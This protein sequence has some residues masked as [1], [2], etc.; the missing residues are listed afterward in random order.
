MPDERRRAVRRHIGD[1]VP[2]GQFGHRAPATFEVTDEHVEVDAVAPVVAEDEPGAVGPE[3]PEAVDHVGIDDEIAFVET[4]RVHDV[5]LHA[6]V[7]AVVAAEHHD[8]RIDRRGNRAADPLIGVGDLG[9][10]ASACRHRP[11]LGDAGDV[12]DKD[13]RGSVGGEPTSSGRSDI[14]IATEIRHGTGA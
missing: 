11:D 8:R 5:Q 13:D 7:P 3:L 2:P 1:G 6:L 12:G 14:E 9:R 4:R 10:P